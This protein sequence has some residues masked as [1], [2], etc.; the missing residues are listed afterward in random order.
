MVEGIYMGAAA[1]RASRTSDGTSAPGDGQPASETP[2]NSDSEPVTDDEDADPWAHI[3]IEANPTAFHVVAYHVRDRRD[4][5]CA[6]GVEVWLDP[7]TLHEGAYLPWGTTVMGHRVTGDAAEQHDGWII[8][9]HDHGDT[10]TRLWAPTHVKVEDDNTWRPVL[11]DA[12]HGP[13][14]VSQHAH[15]AR[16]PDEVVLTTGDSWFARAYPPWDRIRPNAADAEAENLVFPPLPGRWSCS[17]CHYQCCQYCAAQ[18]ATHLGRAGWPLCPGCE[19]SGIRQHMGWTNDHSFNSWTCV[20]TTLADAEAT[21]CLSSRCPHPPHGVLEVTATGMPPAI[22]ARQYGNAPPPHA[23][24]EAPQEP[25]G[26]GQAEPGQAHYRGDYY[27]PP[28]NRRITKKGLPDGSTRPPGFTGT[29]MPE[30]YRADQPLWREGFVR[31]SP[32]RALNETRT[33]NKTVRRP[34]DMAITGMHRDRVT[35]RTVCEL[36][37][38]RMHTTDLRW[39]DVVLYWDAEDGDGP[40]PLHYDSL[41]CEVIASDAQTDADKINHSRNR[42]SFCLYGHAHPRAIVQDVVAEPQYFDYYTHVRDTAPSGHTYP[43]HALAHLVDDQPRPEVPIYTPSRRPRHQRRRQPSAPRPR[44]RTRTR[45][46][47]SGA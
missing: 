4:K 14:W 35:V 28:S 39:C 34:F 27:F 38:L 32:H 31:F 29:G 30:P 25:S 6:P 43:P 21:C 8:L 15:N 46:R 42:G 9:V 20:Y 24:M 17:S 26:P 19:R 13:E 16:P 22:I 45:T 47:R 10:S 12:D 1:S 2:S 37:A 5:V 23:L 36:I 3:T 41:L 33:F 18:R 44:T 7:G 11:I 40:Q